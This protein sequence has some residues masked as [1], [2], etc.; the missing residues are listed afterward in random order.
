MRNR[1]AG[2]GGLRLGV[3]VGMMIFAST[4]QG[5][6]QP[7]KLQGGK[8]VSTQE[9]VKQQLVEIWRIDLDPTGSA[10]AFGKPQLEGDVYVYRAWPEKDIV[11][12]PKTRVKNMTQRTK[13]LNNETI[14]QIDLVP[15]GRLLSRAK[16]KLQKG[17]YLFNE[18]KNGA[19]MSLRQTDVK[20]VTLL[21]GLPAFRIQQEEMGAALIDNLP[22]EG[23]GTVQ[24]LPA[25]GAASAS[26]GPTPGP[27][28]WS[29]QGAPGST[30]AY[31]PANATVDS[32]GDV[33]KAP[34]PTPPPPPQ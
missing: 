10:F 14:Y 30:D 16:P 17:S 22:M 31:A 25:P 34:E 28:N 4:L 2:S 3:A 27:G 12:L 33:P 11:R 32:P 9:Q 7:Q 20:K 26:P 1:V 19:L 13:D 23:G 15:S 6:D 8:P 5:Q 18:Y 21:T 29:Y 24:I